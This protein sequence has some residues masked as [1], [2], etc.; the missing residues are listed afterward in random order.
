MEL[1][2]SRGAENDLNRL[3]DFLIEAQSS[4]KTAAKAL[5]AIKE[6]AYQLVAHPELGI[7][8]DDD[9]G[10]REWRIP[11]GKNAYILRYIP[12]YDQQII[13]VLR[14]YHSRENR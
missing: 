10:R 12:G 4:R 8:L 7:S 6:G 5:R 14:V 3:F 13:R 9:T 2:F 11:F 1:Q